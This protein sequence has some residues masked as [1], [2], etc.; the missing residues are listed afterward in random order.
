MP[1]GI[2]D[3]VRRKTRVD[4]FLVVPAPRSQEVQYFAYENEVLSPS[5]SISARG[6]FILHAI[7]FSSVCQEFRGAQIDQI[8]RG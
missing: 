1:V 8:C 7:D 6:M 3:E 5:N 4:F 2:D